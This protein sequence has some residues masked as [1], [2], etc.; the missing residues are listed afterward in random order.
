MPLVIIFI[1]FTVAVL[2][3]GIIAM[4]KGGSIENKKLQNK[5]MKFRIIFQAVAI[6]VLF[7]AMVVFK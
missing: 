3:V 2:A 1:I 7:F 6:V 5:L 4:V